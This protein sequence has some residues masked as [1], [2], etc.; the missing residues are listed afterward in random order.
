MLRKSDRSHLNKYIPWRIKKYELRPKNYMPL[1]WPRCYYN[2]GQKSQLKQIE[3][4]A[5]I[6]R[7]PIPVGVIFIFA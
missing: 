5:V 4:G 3:R 2:L 1:L 6:T 7:A